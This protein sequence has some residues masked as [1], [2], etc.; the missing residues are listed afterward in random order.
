VHRLANILA[1]ER[2]CIRSGFVVPLKPGKHHGIGCQGAP[3]GSAL[4][5]G[6]GQLPRRTFKYASVARLAGR[7]ASTFSVL[8]AICET[9][10]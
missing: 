7:G 2:R 3:Q 1:F 6:M 8:Q 4:H 9:V 10:H 5:P